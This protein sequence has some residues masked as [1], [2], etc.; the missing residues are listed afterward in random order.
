MRT[1]NLLLL[2]LGIIIVTSIV[3]IQLYPSV[4]D[5]MDSNAMWNGV[6]AFSKKY[7]TQN[8]NSLEIVAESPE[9]TVLISIPYLEY[10]PEEMEKLKQFTEKGGALIIMDDFGYGNRLLEYL[11]LETRF[12]VDPLLDPLFCYKNPYLPRISDFSDRIKKSGVKSILLNHATVLIN[13]D[14]E[15]GLAWSSDQSFLDRNRN[16]EWEEGEAQGPFP[17][18]AEISLGRGLI[19]LVSDTG[20]ITNSML[21]QAE[22]EQF[23]QMLIKRESA[24]YRVI[25]D[26][27]HLAKSPLDNSKEKLESVREALT[28]PYLLAGVMAVICGLAVKF[29]Y[30]KGKAID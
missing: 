2:T 1:S 5:F 4:Q 18:A 23:M 20:M 21:G 30:R 28:S 17:V 6:R 24:S 8:T 10:S 12:A 11:G 29:T 9:D 27:S 25:L 14:H 15:Q 13:I 16:G 3:S 26:Q 7:Q 22:N 19:R